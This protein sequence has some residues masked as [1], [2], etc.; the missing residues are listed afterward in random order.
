[1]LVEIKKLDII[2]EGYK[3]NISIN[4]VYINPSHIISIRDYDGVNN[5]LLS[6]SADKLAGNS[7]CLIKL[8]NVNGVEELIALG[9]SE[10]IQATVSGGK[11]ILNG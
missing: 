7:Y 9:T 5:F 6:E 8:N 10:Q 2:N 3:R 1:M 11:N 4:K